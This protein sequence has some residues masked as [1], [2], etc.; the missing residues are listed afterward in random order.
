MRCEICGAPVDALPRQEWRAIL[1]DD[2]LSAIGIIAAVNSWFKEHDHDA[3]VE[4]FINEQE[5]A[6]A[7]A[8][9]YRDAP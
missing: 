2:D 6:N 1:A 9:A 7:D 5:Q 8:Y 3:E 4:A